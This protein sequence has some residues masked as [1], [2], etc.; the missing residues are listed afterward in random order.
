MEGRHRFGLSGTVPLTLLGDF[1]IVYLEILGVRPGNLSRSLDVAVCPAKQMVVDAEPDI[2][3]L[4]PSAFGEVSRRLPVVSLARAY[5]NQAGSQF[6]P[7]VQYPVQ[8]PTFLGSKL[9]P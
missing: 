2:H 4:T 7:N 8:F 6:V 5:V 1:Q 3:H 9:N